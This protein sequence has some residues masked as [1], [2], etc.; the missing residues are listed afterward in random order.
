MKR[1]SKKKNEDA[2]KANANAS[3]DRHLID[4]EDSVELSIE[5]KIS[6]YWMENKAF[7]AGCVILVAVFLVGIN[8]VKMYSTSQQANLQNEYTDALANDTLEEFALAHS[9]HP[10]S[11][12]SFLTL[13]DQAYTDGDFAAAD[14]YYKQAQEGLADNML[15]GRARLGQAFSRYRSGSPEEGIAQLNAIHSDNTL[16]ASVLA[17]AA[18]HLAI[19]AYAEGDTKTF[20][21]FSSRVAT[22]DE[23]GQWQRRIATYQTR[24]AN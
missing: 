1:P 16:P 12:L 7:I 23:T 11:G 19:H 20:Q 8:G 4:T 5:D 17:E 3:D 14:A 22:L 13:A 10:L 9:A 18:Y 21:S 6:L 2:P 15:A 24:T